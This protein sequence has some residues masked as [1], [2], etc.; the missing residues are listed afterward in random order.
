[1]TVEDAVLDSPAPAGE[2][3]LVALITKA[4]Q[5]KRT[6]PRR[7]HE[8]LSARSRYADRQLLADILGDV[9]AGA[10]SPLEMRFL[11]DVERPHGCREEIDS[12]VDTDWLTSAMWATTTIKSW[13]RSTGEQVTKVSGASQT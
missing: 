5:S 11:H 1:L 4:V 9:A 3:D 13:S 12:G 2:A 8:A 7:L 10:E 6:I